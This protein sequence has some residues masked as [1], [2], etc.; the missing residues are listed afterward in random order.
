MR[1]LKIRKRRANLLLLA[2]G[3]S[4]GLL[5]RKDFK[6]WAAAIRAKGQGQSSQDG[7]HFRAPSQLRQRTCYYYHQP[8][9]MKRDCPQ[10]QGS[11]SYGT[12]QYQ[13]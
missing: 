9:H 6:D 10:R 3:R 7:R 1:V 12:P 5:L 2:Q 11:Q 8:G 13:S 4:R